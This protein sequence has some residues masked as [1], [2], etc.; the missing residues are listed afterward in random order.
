M[1]G[2]RLTALGIPASGERSHKVLG[3]ECRHDLGHTSMEFLGPFSQIPERTSP[4][5]LS[6]RAWREMIPPKCMAFPPIVSIDGSCEKNVSSITPDWERSPFLNSSSTMKGKLVKRRVPLV[7]A[8]RSVAGPGPVEAPPAFPW[9]LS[10][11]SHLQTTA[12][13]TGTYC[14]VSGLWSATVQGLEVAVLLLEGQMMPTAAGRPVQWAF[15]SPAKFDAS[16][17]PFGIGQ[18][19]SE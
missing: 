18:T 8:P 15:T 6:A 2:R 5:T 12:S 14:P 16:G 4:C 11:R 3:F 13:A 19:E 17:S 10:T 1:W 7:P 9:N